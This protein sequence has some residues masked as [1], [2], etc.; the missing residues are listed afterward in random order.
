MSKEVDEG[1]VKKGSEEVPGG[2][3]HL[4]LPVCTSPTIYHELYN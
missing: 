1:K 3:G 2:T 4:Q